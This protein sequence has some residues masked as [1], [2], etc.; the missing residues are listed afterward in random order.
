VREAELGLRG[1]RGAL[2]ALPK[3]EAECSMSGDVQV[4]ALPELEVTSG[5]EA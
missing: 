1:G 4:E 5:A 2:G 3:S